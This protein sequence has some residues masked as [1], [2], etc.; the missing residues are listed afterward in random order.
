MKFIIGIILFTFSLYSYAQSCSGPKPLVVP[1]CS[2]E[3]KD[4]SYI[5]NCADQSCGPKPV[6]NVGCKVGD[7]ENGSWKMECGCG[8]K[9]LPSKGCKITECKDGK[10]EEDCSNRKCP[11]IKPMTSPGCKVECN[12][13]VWQQNCSKK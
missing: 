2:V 10:W 1:G 5:Q 4:G 9:P 3:C 8:L 11:S 13:G 12:E 7:C 6:P